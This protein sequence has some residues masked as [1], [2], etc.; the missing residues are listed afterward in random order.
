M[1][2][3]IIVG[4]AGRIRWWGEAETSGRP[5]GGTNETTS[6]SNFNGC[7]RSRY[8]D[9]RSGDCSVVADFK[10]ATYSQLAEIDRYVVWNLRPVRQI[11]VGSNR[12]QIPDPVVRCGRNRA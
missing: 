4:H 3:G 6:I 12:W 2:S 11:C 5:M 10:M 8:G 1:R 9:S 7:W